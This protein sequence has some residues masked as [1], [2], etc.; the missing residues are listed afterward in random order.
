VS[1]RAQPNSTPALGP[2]TPPS[3]NTPRAAT[4]LRATSTDNYNK[5]D[6][7]RFTATQ[8][9]HLAA[10]NLELQKLSTAGNGLIP[11]ITEDLPSK[12]LIVSTTPA[13][14]YSFLSRP[15]THIR[16]NEQ[17]GFLL[18]TDDI[19][20]E[21]KRAILRRIADLIIGYIQQKILPDGG[22][23]HVS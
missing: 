8:H 5:T 3:I 21:M 1:I 2:T 19:H 16:E 6:N 10:I 18:A 22:S 20:D 11:L 13:T 15:F 14:S 12:A 17:T 9:N 7:Q 4:I 23:K